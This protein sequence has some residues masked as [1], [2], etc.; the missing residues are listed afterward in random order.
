M[1][2][3]IELFSPVRWMRLQIR[4]LEKGIDVWTAM[5]LALI[6]DRRQPKSEVIWSTDNQAR[7]RQ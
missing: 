5:V 4:L 7:R 3:L 6:E 2:T 1:L